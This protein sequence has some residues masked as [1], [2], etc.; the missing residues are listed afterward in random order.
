MSGSVVNSPRSTAVEAQSSTRRSLLVPI[1]FNLLAT[2][3]HVG[4]NKEVNRWKHATRCAFRSM[5][6]E[7]A[8]RSSFI[9]R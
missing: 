1:A 3:G 4:D 6:V 8:L 5:V 7:L 2:A 9:H